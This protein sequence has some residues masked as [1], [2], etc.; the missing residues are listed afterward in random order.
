MSDGLHSAIPHDLVSAHGVMS[1]L[2][3]LAALIDRLLN[4]AII[5]KHPYWEHAHAATEGFG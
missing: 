4:N 3:T 1:L 5:D 2:G